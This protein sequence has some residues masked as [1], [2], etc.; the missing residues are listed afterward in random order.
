M[1]FEFALEII[2]FCPK[3]AN[4]AQNQGINR[5]FC[6]FPPKPLSAKHLFCFGTRFKK[7]TASEQGIP[8][9]IGRF[10]AASTEIRGVG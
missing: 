7:I 5:E 2:E 3:S 10:P 9:V 1:L 4:S 8:P 6:G